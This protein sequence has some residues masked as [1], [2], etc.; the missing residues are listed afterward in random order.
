L[1][2]LLPGV[3]TTSVHGQTALHVILQPLQIEYIMFNLTLQVP[4]TLKLVYVSVIRLGE[5]NIVIVNICFTPQTRSVCYRNRKGWCPKDNTEQ[6]IDCAEFAEIVEP[7]DKKR[8][9]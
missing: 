7:V 2:G 5:S 6:L 3:R 1:L 4:K 9:E 8:A